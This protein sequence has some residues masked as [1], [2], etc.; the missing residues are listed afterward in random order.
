[1]ESFLVPHYHGA[2]RNLAELAFQQNLYLH[3]VQQAKA[4]IIPYT[5]IAPSMVKPIMSGLDHYTSPHNMFADAS[6]Y[7]SKQTL[8]QSYSKPEQGSQVHK[9]W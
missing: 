4:G 9:V 3:S 7:I 2:P 6:K 1:M 8:L 5:Y